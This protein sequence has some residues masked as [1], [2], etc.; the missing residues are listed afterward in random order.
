MYENPTS[1]VTN[2]PRHQP[3]RA[4]NLSR[5][6]AKF[7]ILR[8]ECSPPNMCISGYQSRRVVNKSKL[9]VLGV[10]RGRCC[11]SR[12]LWHHHLA[13]VKLDKHGGVGLE[14]LDGDRKSEVV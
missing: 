9:V 8:V 1:S 13:S 14:V 4:M 2:S 3:A 12:L 11:G 6:L 10:I 5:D 7:V